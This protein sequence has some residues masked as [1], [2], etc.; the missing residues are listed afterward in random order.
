MEASKMAVTIKILQKE[1]S[2]FS[3]ELKK[4]IF[5]I[6]RL[7]YISLFFIIRESDKQT[8]QNFKV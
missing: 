8:I 1:R 2:R 7:L 3:Y 5:T 6:E 4:R